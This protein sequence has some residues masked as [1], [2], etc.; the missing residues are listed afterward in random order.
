MI[1]INNVKKFHLWV[2]RF[3]KRWQH[4]NHKIQYQILCIVQGIKLINKKYLIVI[5]YKYKYQQKEKEKSKDKSKEKGKNR[6]KIEI[7]IN[8][9]EKKIH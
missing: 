7:T 1:N 5:I 3:I 9:I 4:I 2:I 8:K 6:N